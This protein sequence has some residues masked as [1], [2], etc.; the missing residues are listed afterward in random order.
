MEKYGYPGAQ[1][2][3]AQHT[4]ATHPDPATRERARERAARWIAVVRG[5][6][7]GD[8]AI[9]SRTP[10]RGLP[11]WVTPT[12][13]H[14]GFATGTAAAGGT[15]RRWELDY[16]QRHGLPGG[17]AAIFEHAVRE[18][19][20]TELVSGHRA[21]QPEQ[22]ALPILAWLVG[23]GDQEAA[24][25]LLA[26]IAPFRDR[27][28]FLPEPAPASGLPL[29]V[30]WRSTVAETR[31][32]LR[33]RRAQPRVAV[34][35]DTLAVWN[36]YADRVLELW[37]RTAD[38]FGSGW[39]DEARA[40]LAEYDSLAAEH[41]PSRRHA[42][43]KA[44]LTVLRTALAD[45]LA[46]RPWRRGLVRTVTEAM[47]ARRG[48][49]GSPQ[50][51][52]LR[53]RQA[54]DAARPPHHLIAHAV[55]DRMAA[56]P[57]DTGATDVES[58]AEGTPPAIAAIVRRS[59]AAPA[60][61]LVAA[62]L[63]PSGEVLAELSPR[64]VAQAVAATCPDPGLGELMAGAYLAFRRRR[65]LLL[66]NLQS[67]VRPDEMPWVRAAAAHRV[68][69]ETG[70]AAGLRRL[71]GLAWH[72]FPGTLLPNPM[73]RELSMLSREA[74]LDLPWTEELAA[75]IF[76]GRFAPKFRAAADLAG[77]LLAGSL[78]DRYYRIGYG[79][80]AAEPDFGALCVRRSGVTQSRWRSPAE[81]GMIIEQAQ[82][83]TTHN[84]AV[85][86]ETGTDLPPEAAARCFQ[87]AS[88]LAARGSGRRM[89]KNVAYA[90]REMI[91]HL[92]MDS[93]PERF[94]AS[95]PDDGPLAPA[96]HG[97]RQVVAGG[98]VTPFTGWSTG[99]HWLLT[100]DQG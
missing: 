82:I 28:C 87:V 16:A 91:F 19:R 64:I 78:Y 30:V 37:L 9:G 94:V 95:L 63:V 32:R 54:A 58:L 100:A 31:D 17:R 88:T 7:H 46:G 42:G 5:M 18:D 70:A 23:A 29:D 36:L 41:P 89:V 50:H 1:L 33:Q 4:A 51:R 45:V 53:E 27:L 20:L 61:T 86:W 49:P 93:A 80:L 38:D 68:S 92:A 15:L 74:G 48:E 14:G 84:L 90:W 13:T 24:A 71:A 2:G 22:A 73:V 77:G 34:M 60:E 52:E 25:A 39:R 66:L 40:L 43:P 69:L 72:T 35:N 47:V 10:V 75:D 11:A 65:S 81:N 26:E 57:Q 21:E 98:T 99:R 55:A 85:L 76:E 12:V 3:K 83:L 59:L 6:L 8:L 79:D 44:N 67:Q 97:L 96:V 62:G 56:L